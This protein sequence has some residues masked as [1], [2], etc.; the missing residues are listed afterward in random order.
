M[1]GV[2]YRIS[3][4]RQSTGRQFAAKCLGDATQVVCTVNVL[5][6]QWKVSVTPT[7]KQAVGTSAT[8]TLTVGSA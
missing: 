4:I 1:A 5:A 6:G 3:A 8:T 7:G 2:E